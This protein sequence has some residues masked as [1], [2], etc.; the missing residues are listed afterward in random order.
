M[1]EYSV[2]H[3]LA[4]VLLFVGGLYAATKPDNCHDNGPAIGTCVALGIA[5]VILFNT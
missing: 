2:L 1:N 3:G 5:S 4:Y